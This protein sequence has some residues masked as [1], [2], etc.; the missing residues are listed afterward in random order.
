MARLEMEKLMSKSNDSS[1][2]DHHTLADSELDAVTGGTTVGALGYTSH[3]PIGLPVLTGGSLLHEI[4][5]AFL[6][7]RHPVHHLRSHNEFPLSL[8][9]RPGGSRPAAEQ[10]R[11]RA[12]G[13]RSCGGVL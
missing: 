7:G 2:L 3:I 9:G 10:L 1:K 5:R 11:R 4:R 6:S 12:E 8:G 13:R